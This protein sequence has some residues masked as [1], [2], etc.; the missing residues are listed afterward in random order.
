LGWWN[1]PTINENIKQVKKLCDT[2]L[3]KPYQSNAD[4]LLVHY[5][6]SFYHLGNDKKQAAITHWGNNWPTID[7]FKSGVVHHVIHVPY[8]DK[9]NLIP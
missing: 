1:E 2:Q 8:L 3:H 6:E 4:V 7:I 9:I 5:T